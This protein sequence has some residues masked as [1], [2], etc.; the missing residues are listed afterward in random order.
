MPDFAPSKRSAP[1][2]VYPQVTLGHIAAVTDKPADAVHDRWPSNKIMLLSGQT[3]ENR[4][5][6][7]SL[8]NRWAWI[9]MITELQAMVGM[10][11]AENASARSGSAVDT[12]WPGSKS[13]GDGW[14]Q[15]AAPPGPNTPGPVPQRGAISR[16]VRNECDADLKEAA[17]LNLIREYEEHCGNE[18]WMEQTSARDADQRIPIFNRH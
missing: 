2:H 8:A 14:W 15:A 9:K 1:R 3:Q 10:R 13:L 5:I 16:P 12:R 17:L 7:D 11:R 6:T 18:G 4:P